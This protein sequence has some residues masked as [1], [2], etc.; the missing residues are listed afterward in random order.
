MPKNLTASAKT[1]SN[2]KHNHTAKYLI[3]FTPSGAVMFLSAG[4]RGRVSDK[5]ISVDSGY[6]DKISA[7]DCRR[8]GV[9]RCYTEGATFYKGKKPVV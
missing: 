1:W 9:S 8:I 7:R 4:W 2:F 6:F 3:G 5:Q